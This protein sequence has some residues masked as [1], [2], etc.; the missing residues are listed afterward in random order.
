MGKKVISYCLF[1]DNL[2]YCHGIIEA[3][4]SSNIIF[5]DWEVRVYYSIGKQKVPEKVVKILKNLNCKLIEFKE[6]NSCSGEDIEGMMRRFNPIGESDVDYWISRDADSRSS[7][8]EKKMIDEWISSNKTLHSILDHPCHGSLMGGLFGVNNKLLREKYPE[9]AI[10]MDEFILELAN[11][12]NIRRGYDQQWIN[13]HLLDIA[14]KKKDVLV[15]L[16]KSK[17]CIKRCHIGNIK[18]ITEHF[19]TKLID[20]TSNFCGRQINYFPSKVKRPFIEIEDLN[21]ID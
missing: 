8:R 15:H 1:G 14:K 11:K 18:P 17:D 13:K 10:N 9:K 6:V 16:N 7:Y 5:L 3:V 19:E 21:L 4:I 2:K 12:K 20:N